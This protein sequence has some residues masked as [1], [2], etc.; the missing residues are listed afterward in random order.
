MLFCRTNRSNFWDLIAWYF[1]LPSSSSHAL[2]G[3]LIGSGLIAGGIIQYV[4]VIIYL[5]G[6]L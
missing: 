2:I 5:S 6:L 1:G 4:L 3:G